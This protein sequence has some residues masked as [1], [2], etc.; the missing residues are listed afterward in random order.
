MSPVAIARSDGVKH[1]SRGETAPP[2]QN[3]RPG[4]AAARS[5][6][7][8]VQLGK[9]AGND[10]LEGK[11]TLPLIEL[12]LS[13]LPEGTPKVAGTEVNEEPGFGPNQAPRQS[14]PNTGASEKRAVGKVKDGFK[15]PRVSDVLKVTITPMQQT[16]AQ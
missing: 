15:Y 3:R 10:L 7:D 13:R 6:A 8:D 5:L 16:A 1:V 11:L 9:A 14:A 2:G 4:W 12:D